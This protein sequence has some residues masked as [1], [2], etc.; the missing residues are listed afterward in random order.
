[1]SDEWRETVTGRY[2]K[3]GPWRIEHHY[4]TGTRFRVTRFNGRFPEH[5]SDCP[6]LDE[7]KGACVDE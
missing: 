4:A 5:V 3:R 7:A 1:M 2:W 6:T